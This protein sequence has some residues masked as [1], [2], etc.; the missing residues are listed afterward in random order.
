V[1]KFDLTKPGHAALVFST[2]LGGSRDDT[3]NGI[4]VDRAGN[5]YIA[6]TTSSPDFPTQPVA[7][8]TIGGSSDVFLA[9][10]NS[11][12]TNPG[13]MPSIYLV[14]V[15]HQVNGKWTPTTLVHLSEAT[16]FA[17][18]YRAPRSGTPVTG[19]VRLTYHGKWSQTFALTPY[20]DVNGYKVLGLEIN[21]LQHADNRG[22][23]HVEFALSSIGTQVTKSSD[24]TLAP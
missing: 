2:Y 24:F 16:L 5:I 9:K 19:T 10:L 11:V 22:P 1:A 23:I 21:W 4:A 3:A 8:R 18:F 12:S 14:Q 6:G 15:D 20:N 13:N 17:V 7:H